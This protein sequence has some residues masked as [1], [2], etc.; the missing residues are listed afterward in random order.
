MNESHREIEIE[1]D[2]KRTLHVG[3]RRCTATLFRPPMMAVKVLKL[4]SSMHS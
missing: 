2:G 3:R 4:W 1:Y